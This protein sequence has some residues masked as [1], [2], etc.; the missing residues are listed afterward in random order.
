MKDTNDSGAVAIVGVG[1]VLPGSPNVSSLWE[2]LQQGWSAIVETP[3][4]RWDPAKY[5]DP[6]PK[7]PDKTYSKIGGWVLTDNWDPFAWKLPIPPKVGDRMDR[8]QKWA[9]AAAREAL[10]DFGFPDRE[11]DRERTAV[12]VGNAMGGDLHYYSAMRIF[13][14]EVMEA[15]GS[16]EAFEQLPADVRNAV[17]GQML[18]GIRQRVPDI[19]EDTMPGELANIIAGRIAAIFDLHGPNYVTDAACASAMAA[20]TAAVEGLAE[21]HYD[22]VVVGGVDANMSPSTF[23]KFCKIG[24]LSPTGTR[25]YDAGAD[26]FIMGEGASMF[27]LSRL[28]DAE[29]RG[30]RIYAVIRGIGGASDGKGKGITAPNPVGQRLAVRRAWELAGERPDLDTL[31]EGHGTSTRVGDVVEVNSLSEAIGDGLPPQSIPL[32]SIKSNIGHL[33]G[34]A[35]SAGILKATLALHHKAIPPSINL[36]TPNPKIDFARS[37]FFVNTE[38]RSWDRSR[39][40]VRRAGVS[41]FGFGGTNFHAVLEEYEPGRLTRSRRSTVGVTAGISGGAPVTSAAKAPLR[42]AAIIGGASV[43]AVRASLADLLKAAQSARVGPP[44][45]PERSVLQAQMRLGVDYGSAEELADR[46]KL[47]DKALAT[48][49]PKALAPLRARGI[50]LGVGP[51]PPIAFLYTGQGSQYVNMLAEMREREPVVAETFEEADRVMTPILGRPLT[52]YIFADPNDESAVKTAE[53]ELR[54]TAIT[55]PAVLTV[56]AAMTR[57]L[58][59]YGIRPDMVMGHSLGEY[60]ALVAAGGMDFAHALEAVAAR[61]AEMTKVSMDDNGKMA[62]VMGPVTEV[63]AI[64]DEIDGYVVIANL[65]SRKQAVIGGASDAVVRTVALCEARGMRAQLLPVSHAFHTS[66]VAPTSKP[67]KNVL[68]R[69][70]LRAVSIPVVG[71]VDGDFYPTGPDASE[72]M[73]EILGQQVASPVQFVTGLEKLYEAGARVFVEVG[74]KK[75]LHGFAEEVLGD[76]EGVLAL[77]TNHPKQT[78]VTAFNQALVGLYCRGAGDSI[79]TAP[80]IAPAAAVATTR[81]TNGAT[82]GHHRVETPAFGAV[83]SLAGGSDRSIAEVGRMFA[84]FVE[85]AQSL[86]GAP[87]EDEVSVVVTGASLG[88]P[89]GS[90]VFGDDTVV[91][92]LRGHQNI[93]T[94]PVRTRQGMVDRQVTRL[95]KAADGTGSFETIRS[96]GEGIK[97]AGQPGEIR[98]V[99]D[100]GYPEDRAEALDSTTALAI[101][102]GLEALR[103]AGLPLVM[104]YKK[105]T[106]GTYLPERWMLPEALRDDTGVIFGSAF[107][108]LDKFADETEAFRRQRELEA[109][110]TELVSLKERFGQELTSSMRTEIDRRIEAVKSEIDRHRYVL[111]RRFIFRILSMGHS[112]F[113]ELIGARGPNTQVNAACAS[114]TQALGLAEDW[115]RAGRCRRV[116]VLSADNVTSQSLMPWIGSGFLASGAAATDERVED[117]ALPFDRRRHGLI[118]GMGAAGLVVERADDAAQRGLR[119]I[120]EVLGTRFVNS[121]FHG[122]RLDPTH[123]TAQVEALVADVERRFRLRRA[124]MAPQMVFISHETFT[125]ARGGSAQTEV[126]AL[127]TVFGDRADDIVIANTKG[128]TGHAMGTGI[129]DVLGVKALETG[130]V[131]PV[132]NHREVDPEL[133]SL[134]LSRGGSYPVEYALRLGAG[135]GS[136]LALSLIRRIPGPR[137]NAHELGYTSRIEDGARWRAW[138]SEMSGQ[139]TPEVEVKQRTLRVVDQGPS[140]SVV[141]GPR[142]A[143]PPQVAPT[144]TPVAPLS[145]VIAAQATTAAPAAARVQAPAPTP[146]P[147]R[148][149][150]PAAPADGGVLARIMGIVAEQTGYPSD[151][152]DPELDLEADLGIDTVKQAEMF[153]AVREAYGI[154]RDPNLQLRAFNTLNK[155]VDFVHERAPETVKA[156][157]APPPAAPAAAAPAAAPAPSNDVL[158]RIMS[159][160]AEQTGYPPDM[161]DPELDLEAD[162]GIDTVKQAEMFAAV[163]EAYGIE[164]DPNLQLRAFNTLNKVVDFVHERAPETAKPAIA[165]VAVAPAGAV[166][167]PA[168]SPAIADD[169]L[170]RITDIV[171]EQTGYPPDMLDPELDLEADLGIDTV[172][173]AEMFAAVREAYDIER[174]ANLQLREFNTLNK[175]VGFVRDRAP[176]VAAASAATAAPAAEAPAGQPASER[177]AIRDKITGIIAEQTGYPPDMLD[178]ELD[179]EADLGIDTVKQAEMFAAVREAYDIERD[180]NLQLRE[181]N[182]LEKVVDFVIA[183][184][185]AGDGQATAGE[186]AAVTAAAVDTGPSTSIEGSL[187]AAAAIPRRVPTAA[188]LPRIEWGASTGVTLEGGRR[189]AVMPDLGG[190]AGALADQLRSR[191][192]EVIMLDRDGGTA[193]VGEID[194][195]FWLPALDDEGPLTEMS[196]DDFRAAVGV[197]VKQLHRWSQVL[198]DCWAQSGRFFV[199]AT[200]MGGEHGV[201]ASGA[202]APLGGSV[203]GFTKTLARERP[204]ALVK[205]VDFDGADQGTVAAALIEEALAHPGVVEVGRRGADRVGVLLTEEPAED[206]QSGTS[207]GA[208]SVIAVTGAAGSI[209]SAITRDL[210][211]IAPGATFHLLDL[212]PAP[213]PADPDLVAFRTDRDGLKRTLAA[214]MVEAGEKP[215][216]VKIEKQLAG[217]E[218]K[219]AALDA[220]QAIEASGGKLH[221]HALDLRDHDAMRDLFAGIV[222][223]AGRLDLLVHAGGLEISRMLPN[224][225]ADE[226]D[227]VFDVKAQGWWSALVGCGDILPRATVCFSSIAGRFGNAGQTD[228]AAANDLLAK[229]SAAL[230]ARGVRAMVMDWTAWGGIGMATRGSIPTMM[231]QAGIDMLPPDAGI[232]YVRRELTV[233]GRA[234][235]VVVAKALGVLTDARTDGA[236]LPEDPRGPMLGAVRR[237][238]PVFSGFE[239]EVILDP[240]SAPFLDDHR[241]EGTPVLPGVMGLEGFAELAAFA[242]STVSAEPLSVVSI[243]NARFDAPFKI[244][245]D[246]PR[247]AEIRCRLQRVD[248]GVVA[249]ATLIGRRRPA[250]L[251]TEVLTQHFSASV[252]LAPPSDS[253]AVHVQLSGDEGPVVDRSSIYSVYFH[254]PAYQVMDA[255]RRVGDDAVGALTRNLPPNHQPEDLPLTVAPRWIEAAFQAEGVRNIGQTK[256]MALPAGLDRVEVFDLSPTD[257]PLLAVVSPA[258]NGASDVRIVDTEGRVRLA[259]IGYRTAT[260]PGELPDEL[261]GPFSQAFKGE[262]I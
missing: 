54:Q 247:V 153:S 251:D 52:S 166:A 117:A 123:I 31:M 219:A 73:V 76:R 180:A 171:A 68:R 16:S 122:T 105:T 28:E 27:V 20:M 29:R 254:G 92:L 139:D 70:D 205:A 10:M 125:P 145:A 14:P 239:T 53:R 231:A 206:G 178:P 149:E 195:L 193:D 89:G 50:H 196:I 25:P 174:D 252:R 181:F 35:G 151:M 237:Y 51:T 13:A 2:N 243:D 199:A 114:G 161:L 49:N 226:F 198:Y 234:S 103:D 39:N 113:A 189:V 259:L 110:Q 210:V 94:I 38:L 160:V 9:I 33:K 87:A 41:A 12:I 150:V 133:G 258:V 253:P 95:V 185:P 80:T 66:I 202:T 64:I 152:L 32:G 23:V 173:Q 140:D 112:Q 65:N 106:R 238:E 82:N 37:P 164:R 142:V 257:G 192:V 175:V 115:I 169:V 255:V 138:L 211:Q 218:R 124:S 141:R 128:M 246:E 200:R 118:L 135:F 217:L 197:R 223:E 201:G 137:R 221:Y 232:A 34:A 130:E 6:D 163:R 184:R 168:A 47:A 144:T 244:F 235:E 242:A 107:P 100:F 222:R 212:A 69:L 104:H 46:L 204:E 85:Q 22:T 147:A 186:P 126:R 240:A 159:I 156:T 96:S 230:R 91:R 207:F 48:G 120:A 233:G 129:E 165:P 177:D 190:V 191:N 77:F 158:Q 248:D 97:L 182:T 220:I 93:D 216:P 5:Y 134:N 17:A 67:L 132:P 99:E 214:R 8:T 42:G 241:I 183:R 227:L 45:P 136:Q 43:E 81:P 19:T 261:V 62:A 194:G 71:N 72:R 172:K 215:T 101:A 179:L 86:L 167:A 24:A 229:T 74:P 155:V 224:K 249:H 111:D 40:G 15:L 245:R 157:I 225:S 21:H 30:D 26:G 18:Q 56:D 58:A 116:V 187:E 11:L 75:A 4:D 78:D 236:A 79:E 154:E 109:R 44:T 143:A 208:D 88:L 188:L 7:A 57:L 250:G 256:T 3:P 119:P 59:Q 108:G 102:A 84:S 127:R 1:A 61:G 60:G 228:Y 55:Q 262:G 98:L 203:T 121:A 131:P 146:A 213:N 170:Q 36:Q 148:E 260:L 176:Q 90:T 83:P 209:T 63:Q 162:L